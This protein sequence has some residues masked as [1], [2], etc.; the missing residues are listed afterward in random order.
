MV[1]RVL[2][3]ALAIFV[4]Q[5]ALAAGWNI[6]PVRLELSPQQQ[7]AALTVTN[8]SDQPT[9]IQI[10]AVA[11]SQ[12]EGKDVFTPTKEVLVSP[13][14]VTIPA[15]GEQIIRVA[16][17][18]KADAVN[19]LTYRINLQELPPPHAPEFVG[20]QVALRIGLPVFVQS[21]NGQAAAKVTWNVSQL[22]DN[23]LKVQA[24]NKG[25]AHI[26]ISDFALY[27]PGADKPISDQTG[28][29]YILSGQ[30]HEWLLKSVSLGNSNPDR[31]RL[32]AY[33]DA[34]NIDME[35]VLGKP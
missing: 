3:C 18:R 4:P 1:G 31:L 21:Q 32:K 16:L 5:I 19:E 11:W 12:A 25:N 29:S 8:E 24:Q 20:V 35:L 15:K 7:T 10:Q 26:Q 6:D 13:P 23:T 9:S 30:S 14:F 17:R 33:S 22:A 2:F 28:S 34:D 27:V